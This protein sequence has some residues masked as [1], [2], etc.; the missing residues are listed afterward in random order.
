MRYPVPRLPHLGVSQ[1]QHLL[2][3]VIKQLKHKMFMLRLR[4]R[5]PPTANIQ[6]YLYIF[7]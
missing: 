6:K 3:L 4:S 2:L 1:L 5:R 7:D